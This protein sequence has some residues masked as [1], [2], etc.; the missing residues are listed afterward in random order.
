MKILKSSAILT[1]LIV[2]AV[3][4][5]VSAQN[6]DAYVYKPASQ[7]LYNTIARMDSVYFTAYNNCDMEKQAAI[8][9]DSIEFYHDRGGL[10][11]SKQNLLTA[12]KNNICGKVTRVLVKGSM[13]VYQIPGYGAVE[14]ALH[15][16]INH[17][18]NDSVSKPD[19]FI[20]VWRQ[21]G[22]KWQI[23]RVISLH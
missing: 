3:T 20:V 22:D 5:T 12:I 17:Q 6:N 15:K 9:S 16:F 10:E 7:E 23:T 21:R 11:T 1:L 13:E 19:K 2:L 18:E 4:T 14:I 8:Y